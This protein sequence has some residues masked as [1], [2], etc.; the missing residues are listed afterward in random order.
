MKVFLNNEIVDADKAQISAGD[1]G[2]LYGAGLFET[3]RSKNGTV[4]ALDDHLD[5]LFGSCLKLSINNPY[6][7]TYIADA[8]QQTLE[9][10]GLADARIRLTLS[11]GPI[12][13]GEEA[14]PVPT[15]LITAAKFEPY[16]K[17]LYE[18]GTMV[19]LSSFRQN[20]GDPLAGHKSTSYYSRLLALNEARKKGA[21]ESLWFTPDN[22]LA[23]GC[24]S[25]VF[26]VK[27]SV[28]CTP[29]IE[30]PVLPGI[31][32]K[33]ICRIAVDNSIELIEKEL[34][35]NDLLD[36]D[37]VFL[38]NVIMQVLPV[39]TIEAHTVGDG[40]VGKVGET[41]KSLMELFEKR[42]DECCGSKLAGK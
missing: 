2:F 10:N 35:I 18:K 11:N 13:L 15:L 31:A 37:E 40:K 27:D 42:I 41:T 5:R 16:P 23:E 1:S 21:T 30:T 12:R 9:A 3:M 39:T 17:Y 32:R 4:F 25:N 36:A 19:V 14:A 7:K 38:T 6:D 8:L 33:T 34:T 22:R 28:I 20:P 26:I 24:V 29:P